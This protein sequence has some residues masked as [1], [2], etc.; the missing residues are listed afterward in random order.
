MST[1]NALVLA[2][3][4]LLRFVPNSNFSG[5]VTL[6][7]VAGLTSS[8]SGDFS[9]GPGDGSVYVNLDQSTG[10]ALPAQDVIAPISG[11]TPVLAEINT[12]VTPLLAGNGLN[13]AIISSYFYPT[14]SVLD[15]ASQTPDAAFTATDINY[16]LHPGD[17]GAQ[18][19]DTS[20]GQWLNYNGQSDGNTIIDN[21]QTNVAAA[22]V[23]SAYFQMDGYIA[24]NAGTTYTFALNSDDGSILCINGAILIDN[25]GQHAVSSPLT[26]TFTPATSGFYQIGISYFDNSY[27]G[28]S[29][30]AQYSVDGGS[31]YNDLTSAV[32]SQ[33]PLEAATGGVV[34]M[35][36]TLTDGVADS[37]VTIAGLPDDLSGFSGGGTYTAG[38]GT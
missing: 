12:S 24:L 4:D 33:Q 16:N 1:T 21:A 11:G 6:F 15:A 10:N 18:F 28:A 30:L 35:H 27:G 32:L 17:P 5:P 29:I 13:G 37:L 31:T 8:Y 23:S 25:D 36:G 38:T 14:F 2:A 22:G 9:T 20:I 34:N 19:G 3:N 7:G 26:A